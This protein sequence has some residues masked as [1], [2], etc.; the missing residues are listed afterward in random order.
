MSRKPIK[1]TRYAIPFDGHIVEVDVYPF[2]SDRAV[3]EI[4]LL[5]ED[6]AYTVP[7]CIE[8][9]K[10]VTADKRYSNRALSKQIIT[11]EL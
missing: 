9:I 11:E 5:S 7:E 8:I 6:E 1:K 3:M 4:E 10:E 2:W